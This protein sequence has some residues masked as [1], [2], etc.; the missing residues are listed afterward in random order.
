[1][2]QQSNMI[3][4]NQKITKKQNERHFAPNK[5]DTKLNEDWTD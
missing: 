5:I 4:H 3:S 2:S 1:M